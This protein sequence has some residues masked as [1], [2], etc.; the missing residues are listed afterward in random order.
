M[1]KIP[2]IKVVNTTGN[3]YDTDVYDLETGD[4]LTNVKM[5]DVSASRGRLEVTIVAEMGFEYEGPAFIE[6]QRDDGSL[7]RV[8]YAGLDTDTTSQ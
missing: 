4:K 8:P 5:V 3:P 1:S 2:G 6:A 7:Y